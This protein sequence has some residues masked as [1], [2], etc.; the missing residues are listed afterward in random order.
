MN[1]DQRC[2]HC[3]WW[4][5]NNNATFDAEINPRPQGYRPCGL[6]ETDWQNDGPDDLNPLYPHTNARGQDG[7]R[8]A[9]ILLTVAEFGCVQFEGRDA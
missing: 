8:Y 6:T 9:A 1:H 7:E 2:R 4:G 5:V 3:K